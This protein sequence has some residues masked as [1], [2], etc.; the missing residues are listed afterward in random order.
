M[1]LV[2]NPEGNRPLRK[3]RPGW[4]DSSKIDEEYHHLGC[5]AVWPL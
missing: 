1:L 2:V 4:V 3:P 5:D